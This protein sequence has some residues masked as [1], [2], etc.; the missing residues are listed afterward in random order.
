MGLDGG[1]L[2]VEAD[3]RDAGRLQEARELLLEVL[4]VG[5]AEV[6]ETCKRGIVTCQRSAWCGE[7]VLSS[8]TTGVRHLH[9]RTLARRA[10]FRQTPST[11]A[12]GL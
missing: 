12:A 6:G 3:L 4:R 2:A 10:P 8:H 1:E 7:R 5:A 9:R 11:M